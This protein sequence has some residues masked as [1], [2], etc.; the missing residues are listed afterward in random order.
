[1]RTFILFVLAITAFVGLSLAQQPVP[2]TRPRMEVVVESRFG[3]DQTVEEIKKTALA[4]KFGVQGV[5]EMSK[6][7][8]EKGFPREPLTIVE[9]CNP[10]S[11]SDSLNNDI[12][13]SLM[14]PCP[15]AVYQQGGKV[16][17]AMLDTRRV[18]TMYDGAT[19]PQIGAGIYDAL[20]KV[21]AAVEK[22]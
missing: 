18:A 4:Q 2:P 17:V 1:M 6:T 8:A 13:I 5:H 3:F 11:A 21:L 9:V 15:I 19:M 22:K 7:L 12:L 20:I 14:M 16:M 10:K